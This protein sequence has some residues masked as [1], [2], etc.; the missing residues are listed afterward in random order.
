MRDATQ[1]CADAAASGRVARAR[2]CGSGPPAVCWRLT[3]WS[4]NVRR[5]ES[6]AGGDAARDV[7]FARAV[8]VARACAA[9]RRREITR[10]VD[11]AQRLGSHH[12]ERVGCSSHP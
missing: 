2:G 9:A 5:D 1:M 10:Q 11:H 12:R 3:P 4:G 6:A 8:R 7:G